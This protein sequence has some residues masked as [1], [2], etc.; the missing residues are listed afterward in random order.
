MTAPNGPILFNSSTGSDTQASGLGPAT[1]V[2][3]TGAST[4]SASA[5]VTGITTT[6]VT[7]GDLLWVSTSSG[8]QFSIIASVDSGTQVTCDDVF[9][10]TESGRTWAIGGKRATFN[11]ASS[12]TLFVATNGAKPG[13][14]LQTETD[15]TIGSVL[16]C[17][18][19]G[20][21][22]SRIVIRGDSTTRKITQTANAACL[23]GGLAEWDIIR[24]KFENTNATKTNAYGILLNATNTT[25]TRIRDCIFG[26]PTN[27]LRTGLF[28]SGTARPSVTI[29]D[30]ITTDCTEDGFTE[31]GGNANEP[32]LQ[33]INCTATNNGRH[34]INVGTMA[35]GGMFSVSRCLVHNNAS[36][37]IRFG[38]LSPV[39]I[40][41]SVI[42]ANGS[43]GV[44]I[45]GSSAVSEAT[46]RDNIITENGGRGIITD[47]DGD[48][49]KAS[50]DYNA[51]FSNTA[52]EVSG[53]TNGAN[54]ITL[55][56]DPFI[57]AENGDFNINNTAGGGA[58][59]R[60]SVFALPGSSDT[61]LAPFR[62]W[63]DPIPSGGGGGFYISQPARML[64]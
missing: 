30:S 43:H 60:E 61:N 64:R 55:T 49:L 48:Q 40:R 35:L 32:R 62:Q 17:L 56:A 15:Q 22:T 52:G 2:F 46:I 47:A 63:L 27:K 57:D 36:A 3:G 45:D 58:L 23:S 20:S 14:V 44:E 1:A 25:S 33:L 50:I 18:A 26:D 38:G 19:A 53:I 13:W 41:G 37:G 9:A 11:A 29:V 42:T 34:G 16:A 8:R 28:R 21:S 4:T 7:A 6:G 59:L 12:R 24:L 39:I 51:F 10:N 31:P 5:V 54:D